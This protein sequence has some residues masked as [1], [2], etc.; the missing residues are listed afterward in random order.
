MRG[1]HFMKNFIKRSFFAVLTLSF[2]G[3]CCIPSSWAVTDEQFLALQK[4]VQVLE[5]EHQQDQAEIQNLKAQQGQVEQKT[6]EIKKTADQA[7]EKASM[8]QPSANV[9][10]PAEN[11]SFVL[12]GDAEVQYTQTGGAN[13][14]HSS[15]RMA[16]FA[17]VFLYRA[18]DKVLFEAGF[19][20]TIDNGTVALNGGATGASGSTTSFDLTFAQIDY[21]FNDYLTVIGGKMILPLGTYNERSAGWL[22]KIADDPMARS[23]L[24]SQGVGVQARGAKAIGE[25]GQMVTYSA[26]STNGA[27]AV[28]VTGNAS[29]LDVNVATL[30]NIDLGGNVTNMHKRPS[31]GGRIGWFFPWKPHYDVELGL[32]GQTGAWDSAGK[33][34]W[35]AG[36]IDAAIHVSPY[37]ETKGEY[38]YT[39]TGTADLGTID[40]SGW[41]L[42]SG[43]KMSYFNWDLPLIPSTEL[44]FRYD[45]IND[46]L[47]PLTGAAQKSYR[48]TPGLV[49]YITNSLWLEGS[50]EKIYNKGAQDANQ[51]LLQLSYGF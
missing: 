19:D 32:S 2:A 14:A 10:V 25:S 40:S 24:I 26:Y 34:T 38:I 43:F 27:G 41:W 15:Y 22:N 1:I 49:Y 6:E 36:V 46:P 18:N 4:E 23:L 42:Q 29:T 28:D 21:L 3:L 5:Q 12:A 11:H 17:P 50:Y 20:T 47:N 31:E 44:V 51:W 30:R 16:D 13:K 33:E 7:V 39:R 9:K 37:F 45:T 8:V 35:N 48:Y